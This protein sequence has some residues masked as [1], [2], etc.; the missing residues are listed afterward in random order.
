MLTREIHTAGSAAN[1]R[2]MADRDTI[3]A[4]GK[5]LSFI[6][7]EITDKDGNLVPDADNLVRFDVEG[8]C[9]IAGV[10]NGSQTSTESFKA[11]QRKAFHGKALV[12][13]Q[14]NGSKG[15]ATL[16][17]TSEGLATAAMTVRAR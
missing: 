17:A 9:F 7:V 15:T 8:S 14:N 5:D 16:T 12:V 3:D 6:T 13:L 1:I 2:L 11:P 10:D 4:D